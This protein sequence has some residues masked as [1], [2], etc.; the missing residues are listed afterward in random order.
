MFLF[1]IVYDDDHQQL[2]KNT[3]VIVKRVTYVG[4][5]GG[6][7]ARIRNEEAVTAM[8]NTPAPVVVPTSIGVRKQGEYLEIHDS[9][10]YD[11]MKQRLF[12]RWK[13]KWKP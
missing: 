3:S 1:Y 11:R 7:L 4:N 13:M 6:L 2:S 12:K 9:L 5:M 10:L 8:T